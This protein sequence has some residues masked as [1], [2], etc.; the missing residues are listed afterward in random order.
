MTEIRP[1]FLKKFLNGEIDSRGYI[2]LGP[3]KPKMP[4]QEHLECEIQEYQIELQQHKEAIEL[5]IVRIEKK[6][7]ELE[8]M[9]PPTLY[10]T[11]LKKT[12]YYPKVCGEICDVVAEWLPNEYISYSEYNEGWNE[13]LHTIKT[14]L[15]PS[16]ELDS[17][18]LPYFVG[19]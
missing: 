12:E 6:K 15:R 8:K 17:K 5:I 11:L 1:E 4:E 14:N 9:K 13:C 3:P 7:K 18:N 2:N 16:Q 10:E 19:N